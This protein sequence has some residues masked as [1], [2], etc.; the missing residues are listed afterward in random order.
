MRPTHSYV[1]R[2]SRTPAGTGWDIQMPGVKPVIAPTIPT[3]MKS[4][5]GRHMQ[6]LAECGGREARVFVTVEIDP[7][8]IN[9]VITGKIT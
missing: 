6:R 5:L 2:V 1:I 8:V 3:A 9:D 7:E 4:A